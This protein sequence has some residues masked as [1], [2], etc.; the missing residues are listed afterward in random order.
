[1]KISLEQEIKEIDRTIREMKKTA[2]LHASLQEKLEQQKKIRELESRRNTKRKELY[3][4]QDA[5]DRRRDEL[6]D[7]IERQLRQKH[8]VQ[9]I[10][11]FRWTLQ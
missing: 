4:S 1:M 5:I 9:D 3:E 8:S 7:N 2:T 6:I 11:T 10:F